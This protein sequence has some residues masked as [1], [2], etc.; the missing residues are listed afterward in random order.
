[1]VGACALSC[2][3]PHRELG[4][5]AGGVVAGEVADEL[6][7]TGSEGEGRPARRAG[8]DAVAGAGSA[9][10]GRFADA[11]GLVDFAVAAL[12]AGT[13]DLVVG[14][15]EHDELVV[16]R[17]E[18]RRDERHGRIMPPRTP[19]PMPGPPIMGPPMFVTDTLTTV[20]GRFGTVHVV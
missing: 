4:V 10:V 17:S 9:G 16:D 13:D 15:G 5:H 2:E 1:M 18:I 14:E 19:P 20:P 12:R 11:C 7:P 3:L 6:V 8:C